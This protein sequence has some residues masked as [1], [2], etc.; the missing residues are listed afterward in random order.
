MRWIVL[1]FVT[2]SQL[3]KY[4]YVQMEW[5]SY[6]KV[7]HLVTARNLTLPWNIHSWKIHGI[8]KFLRPI[9]LWYAMQYQISQKYCLMI[10]W[11]HTIVFFPLIKLWCMQWNH[12]S[13]YRQTILTNDCGF[14]FV[15]SARLLWLLNNSVTY[16]LNVFP[17]TLFAVALKLICKEETV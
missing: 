6:R 2:V 10:I 4:M 12:H 14:Q 7:F 8:L 16:S 9:F 11:S 5:Y 15:L 1:W 13:L 17:C 3:Y